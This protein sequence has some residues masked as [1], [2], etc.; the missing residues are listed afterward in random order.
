MSSNLQYKYFYKTIKNLLQKYE[1]DE[2]LFR[3][4]PS[5]GHPNKEIES[6]TLNDISKNKSEKLYLEIMVNFLG[7]QGA[8]SQL[9]SYILEKLAFNN[10]G[11]D[12]WTLLFD[13][14]NNYIT[15][16][17]Y[18][19]V[20]MSSYAKSF[21][22]ELNDNI[23][24]I[25]LSFLGI[26]N[27][28]IAKTYLPFAPLVANLR[29][30]KKQIERILQTTFNLKDRLSI[31]ENLPHHIPIISSQQNY[32]GI[33]NCQLGKNF[34][35]GKSVCSYQT[36][37]GVLIDNLDYD[38]AL[39]FF[40]TGAKFKTLKTSIAFLTNDEFAI[41]LYLRIKY[42]P[43]MALKLGK[44]GVRLGWGS[45]LGKSQNSSYTM[46]IPLNE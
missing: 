28:E 29:R 4:N 38:E 34:I 18:D 1:R 11:G 20:S 35:A 24:N 22:S 46:Q 5:L 37:I 27:K 14:F 42:K 10:D 2:I 33:K 19:V 25:L 3:T 43:K 15:W 8:S 41:D 23:S 16:I 9:P 21:D 36:K 12:G 7:I 31:I 13:F 30:P 40:P 44:N 45:T 26:K 6:I 39:N 17:F 32:L